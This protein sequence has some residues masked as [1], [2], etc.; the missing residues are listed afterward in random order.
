M[1]NLADQARYVADSPV[2]FK[3]GIRVYENGSFALVEADPERGMYTY[4]VDGNYQDPFDRR[5]FGSLL[6]LPLS[7]PGLQACCCCNP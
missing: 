3:R 5:E 1:L 4:E 2:I 7:G 6:R